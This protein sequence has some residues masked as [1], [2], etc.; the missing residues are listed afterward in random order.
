[1]C[2][3]NLSRLF[4]KL[5]IWNLETVKNKHFNYKSKQATLN[6][7]ILLLILETVI[8]AYTSTMIVMH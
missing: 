2:F 1:M 5:V 6:N 3:R 8:L 7:N 4:Y